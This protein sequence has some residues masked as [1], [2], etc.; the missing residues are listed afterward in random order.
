MATQAKLAVELKRSEKVDFARPLKAFISSSYEEDPNK[1]D[2]AIMNLDSLRQSIRQP[3]KHETGAASLLKYLGQLKFLESRF[4][5]SSTQVR[6]EFVWYDS[7]KPKTK[8]G[9]YSIQYE[10]ACVIFNLASLYSQI[11]ATQNINTED[12]LKVACRY[13]QLAAGVFSDLKENIFTL[14]PTSPTPDL[15]PESLGALITLMLAQAQECFYLKAAMDKMKDAITARLATQAAGY[16]DDC[17]EQLNNGSL[18]NIVDK[19]LLLT[20]QT[21][22]SYYKAAAQFHAAA[23][24][25]SKDKYG[26]EV[27]RLEAAEKML[28]DIA[29]TAKQ[30]GLE[31]TVL[32]DKVS[33]AYAAA[34]KDN[35]VI[36]HETVPGF[37]ALSMLQKASMV[38]PALPEGYKE[39]EGLSPDIFAGLV[40]FALHQAHETYKERKVGLVQRELR[41]L[42]DADGMAQG[43]LTSF[44][45]PASLEAL[46]Q[47]VG[48]PDA[49]LDKSN[50]IRSEGGLGKLVTLFDNLSSVAR[51]NLAILAETT[52]VLDE[53]ES[54]D[55]QLREQYGT[56]WT[57][58][59]SSDINKELRKEADKYGLVMQ[60]AGAADS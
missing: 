18:K 25:K 49:L 2:E 33:R 43:T 50:R 9:Q 41:R 5:I 54:R 24:C 27:G 11:A 19:T 20:V 37:A 34:A 22:A 36:Y 26:E 23:D 51:S 52:R 42:Q 58:E 32:L 57:R 15:T 16:Y 21:K 4:P 13:Y 38:K 48:L 7:F 35:D 14:V 3:D 31:Y 17:F 55:R 53:E 46:E 56:S 30:V 1:Y 47:P 8:Q 6:V 60:K 40:P 44:N 45:L 12:G 59:A 28:K 10:R 39:P 29:K